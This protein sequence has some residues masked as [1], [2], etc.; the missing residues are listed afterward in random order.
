MMTQMVLL[1]GQPSGSRAEIIFE[2]RNKSK[3]NNNANNNDNTRTIGKTKHNGKMMN[4]FNGSTSR[5]RNSL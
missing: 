1:R 2:L 5:P 4:D 3:K